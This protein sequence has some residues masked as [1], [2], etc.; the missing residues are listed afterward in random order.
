MSF[1]TFTDLKTEVSAFLQRGS[2][3][4]SR[5]SSWITLAEADISKDLR[6]W[7]ME[8]LESLTVTAATAT[9]AL[10][11][12]LRD[13]K[14]VKLNGEYERVL[15]HLP[16]AA[17]YEQYAQADGDTPIHFTASESNL[18]LGP[19][20]TADGTLTALCIL[21]PSPLSD[22]NQTNTILTNYPD[23]Y[24]YA[25]L[26]HAFRHIRNQERLVE[27]VQAYGIAIEKANKESR[28]RKMMATPAGVP[29]LGGRRRIV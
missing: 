22:S 10:P 26:V 2:A 12:R 29:A 27:A 23:V 7:R 28:N 1:D 11:S 16:A 6:V 5:I 4:D 25:T 17:F 20:P 14:W 8:S 21:A 18:I 24:F 19:T 13:I 15:K 9:V 3:F